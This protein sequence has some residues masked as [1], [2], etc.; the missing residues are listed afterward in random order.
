MR[1][2]EL[3]MQVERSNVDR[4]GLRST[5]EVALDA[6]HAGEVGDVRSAH[7]IEH[8][9]VLDPFGDQVAAGLAAIAMIPAKTPRASALTIA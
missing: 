6:A 5:E 8:F 4:T 3:A 2:E 1:D 7:E 9:A